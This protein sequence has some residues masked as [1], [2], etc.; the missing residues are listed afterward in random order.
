[1]KSICSFV[2]GST[3]ITWS[4]QHYTQMKKGGKMSTRQSRRKW[5][6]V[7]GIAVVAAIATVAIWRRAETPADTAAAPLAISV[8]V[9]AAAMRDVPIFLSALGTVQ[10]WN[11]IS[12]HSQITGTLQSVN[13]VQGQEVHKGDTLA[14]IDPR[15]LQA[16]LDQ[17]VAKKAEDEAQLVDDQK[18]LQRFK[19]MAAKDYETQQNVDLQQAKV[20]TTRATINADQAA[21]EAAQTQLSYATI[22]APIDG[23]VG[24]R[25]LDVGNIIHITDPNPLTVITQI[26]PVQIIFTLPQ[27]NLADVREAML[28]GSVTVLAFDQDN[29]H[30][31]AQGEL[32]LIDNQINQTT[33]TI[34][35][36]ASF[37]NDDERLWPGEFVRIRIQVAT[38]KDA[39][40]VPPVAVQRGPNGLYTWVVKPD[41]TVDQRSIETMPADNNVTIVTN[42]VAAGERVVVN[43]QYQLQP[44]S[45]VDAETQTAKSAPDKTS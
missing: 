29:E 20:D 31:L 3:A 11:T 13:F 22:T 16:A 9:A 5:F 38:R 37:P 26:K 45:R 6:C 8:T 15:P 36:K 28:R 18:D 14:L 23:V 35:L 41:N 17:A 39:I 32:M 24:F 19:L 10:A 34:S 2:I 12:I 1:L 30:Q 21:I 42:G 25:Q 44:G 7:A 43:G 40:T 27:K 4:A 33:S